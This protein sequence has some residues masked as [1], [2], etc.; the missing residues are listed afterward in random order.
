[1]ENN[2]RDVLSQ[3]SENQKAPTAAAF[4]SKL[5]RISV[6][7]KPIQEELKTENK[8]VPKAAKSVKL[9]LT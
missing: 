5:K 7:A 9:N 4:V 8:I 3:L 2:H 6:T 1:M